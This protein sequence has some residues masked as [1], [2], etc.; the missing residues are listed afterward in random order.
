[1]EYG[2]VGLTEAE[3]LAQGGCAIAAVPY[4]DLDRAVIDGRAEGFCKLIVNRE[5]GQI[6]GAHV[7]GEQAVEVVQIVA[8]GM[9]SGMHVLELAELELAYPT[10]TAVVG[11]AARQL[12]RQLG[13]TPLAAEWRTLRR[14]QNRTAEWENSSA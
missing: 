3:A 1:P 6:V 12:V 14:L 7:V 8:A 13:F 11:L 5:S 4:S 2:S 10:F 9:A